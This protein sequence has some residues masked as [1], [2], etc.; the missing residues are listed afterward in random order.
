MTRASALSIC[1]LTFLTTQG[2]AQTATAGPAPNAP[3]TTTAPDAS[4]TAA[5]AVPPPY[6]SVANAPTTGDAAELVP[7]DRV[8]HNPDGS[9]TVPGMVMIGSIVLTNSQFKDS[10]ESRIL[11]GRCGHP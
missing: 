5:P 11:D 3:Q 7:C 10:D 1:A 9:W 8:R 6:I 4:Q 2:C